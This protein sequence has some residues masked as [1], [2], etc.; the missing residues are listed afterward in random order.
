MDRVMV[1]REGAIDQFGPR[2]DVLRAMAARQ[3]AG[4]ANATPLRA[5]ETQ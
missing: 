2:E 5:R 1:L 3:A 4:A